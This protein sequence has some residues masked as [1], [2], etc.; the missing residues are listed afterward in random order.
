LFSLLSNPNNSLSIMPVQYLF[1]C[2]LD[3]DSRSDTSNPGGKHTTWRRKRAPPKNGDTKDRP[4]AKNPRRVY[5]Q[6]DENG[7]PI[8]GV[9]ELSMV[10][11][12]DDV[13]VAQ[14]FEKTGW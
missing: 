9:D 4:V 7:V 5:S 14:V 1:V 10:G 11:H 6:V 12:N 8:A 3:E 13:T 2:L